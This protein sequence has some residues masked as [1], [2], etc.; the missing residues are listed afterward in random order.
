M[1]TARDVQ[2]APGVDEALAA[3]Y[4]DCIQNA[5]STGLIQEIALRNWFQGEL[6]TSTGMRGLIYRDEKSGKTGGIPNTVIDL[7][8]DLHIIRKEIRSGS[9][10]YE[11]PHD[12]LI[13][14]VQLA[15]PTTHGRPICC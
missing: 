13:K 14:P 3:F 8:D 10:W 2:S 4:S 1:I 6:I 5:V 9:Q 12:R 15:N 11:L 7:L